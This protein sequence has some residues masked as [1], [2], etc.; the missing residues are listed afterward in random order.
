MWTRASRSKGCATNSP[1]GSVRSTDPPRFG[2]TGP[3]AQRRGDLE[4]VVDTLADIRRNLGDGELSAFQGRSPQV[5]SDCFSEVTRCLSRRA[6]WRRPWARPR[7]RIRR[8]A[9]AAASRQRWAP[10][11]RMHR[12]L[13]RCIRAAGIALSADY[14]GAL[15]RA[16]K[17]AD[18]YCPGKGHRCP[19]RAG[20]DRRQRS[21]GSADNVTPVEPERLSDVGPQGCGV[22]PQRAAISSD[23]GAG[24]AGSVRGFSRAV[25]RGQDVASP[26]L[27][28]P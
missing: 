27:D 16:S 9:H 17:P 4:T 8:R 3:A 19:W 15:P 26:A 2:P 12:C 6:R 11:A 10:P 20:S 23:D 24:L 5:D 25:R 7:R 1:S 28:C 14:A 18:V 22:Q 21:P 13:L